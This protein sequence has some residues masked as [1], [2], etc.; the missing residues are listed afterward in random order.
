MGSNNIFVLSTHEE[1]RQ[2]VTKRQTVTM[3]QATLPAGTVLSDDTIIAGAESLLMGLELRDWLTDDEQEFL[4]RLSGAHHTL[5]F[6]IRDRNYIHPKDIELFPVEHIEPGVWR[7]TSAIFSHRYEGSTTDRLTYRMQTAHIYPGRDNSVILGIFGPE[8]LTVYEKHKALFSHIVT[9]FRQ[10][11]RF[12]LQM[13]QMLQ[14]KLQDGEPVIIVNRA[15]GRLLHISATAA[16]LIRYSADEL[17]GMEYSKINRLLQPLVKDYKLRMENLASG[18]LNLAVIT[19]T[20][21]NK[22]SDS[23]SQITG[24]NMLGTR[25]KLSAIIEASQHSNNIDNEEISFEEINEIA[26]AIRNTNDTI[27]KDLFEYRLHKITSYPDRQAEHHVDIRFEM[28]R[29]VTEVTSDIETIHT[30][31]IE[32]DTAQPYTRASSDEYLQLFETILK[33]HI[34]AARGKSKTLVRISNDGL[35][36]GLVVALTTNLMSSFRAKRFDTKL[37]HQAD[38]LAAILG[39]KIRRDI[40]PGGRIIVTMLHI[41]VMEG[42][43]V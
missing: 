35:D 21:I 11:G 31:E 39:V 32:T 37:L 26:R 7:G 33:T 29:A 40:L 23:K 6:L 15:S 19:L 24:P 25:K 8:E 1:H 28:E 30:V 2:A 43:T 17:L 5:T 22:T 16:Q 3:P 18:D 36:V 9:L 38:S 27:E 20:S 10:A 13:K 42:V 41:P 14:T 34:K 4:D 12:V